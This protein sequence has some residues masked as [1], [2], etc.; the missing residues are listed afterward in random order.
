M[1][2]FYRHDTHTKDLDL[3]ARYR[4]CVSCKMH[5]VWGRAFVQRK[6]LTHTVH[7][8]QTPTFSLHNSRNRTHDFV[9]YI[10]MYLISAYN[11]KNTGN[12]VPHTA[13]FKMANSTCIMFLTSISSIVDSSSNFLASIFQSLFV[14]GFSPT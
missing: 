9:T 8:A 12:S 7:V 4:F 14:I 10:F 3:T 5:S 13:H 1:D 2:G 6:S 11:F